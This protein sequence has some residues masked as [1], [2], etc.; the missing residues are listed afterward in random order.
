VELAPM[1]SRYLKPGGVILLSGL[2][3]EQQSD[4]LD[5]YDEVGFREFYTQE[6]W[7]CLEGVKASG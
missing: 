5:A 4:V 1:L 2:L 7:L 6:P 3:V